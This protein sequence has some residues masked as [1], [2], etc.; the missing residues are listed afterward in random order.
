MGTIWKDPWLGSTSTMPRLISSLSGFLL[1]VALMLAPDW[2]AALK[3]PG[4]P[5]LMQVS[6]K[7]GH[8]FCR[9]S[10]LDPCPWW[11]QN[12]HMGP[13]PSWLLLLP[14]GSQLLFEV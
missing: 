8:P 14:G 2:H 12:V 3:W 6:L 13:V 7:A 10:Q 4:F 1:L 9:S 11:S 5:H